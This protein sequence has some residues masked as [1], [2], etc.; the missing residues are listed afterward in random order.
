[1]WSNDKPI[2]IDW[3]AAGYVNPMQELI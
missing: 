2:I 3:E 1:M